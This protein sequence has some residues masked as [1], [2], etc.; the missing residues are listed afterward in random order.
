[1]ATGGDSHD[2]T[3]A[4][5]YTVVADTFRFYRCVAYFMSGGNYKKCPY[6]A[7][8]LQVCEVLSACV[9]IATL[10]RLDRYAVG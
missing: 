2:R 6:F 4:D 9:L 1:M 8:R 10:E 7:N 5:F 3:D